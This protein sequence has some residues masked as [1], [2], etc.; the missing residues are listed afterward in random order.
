MSARKVIVYIAASADG[1][2][3]KPN[4][5]LSFLEIVAQEGED[6]GYAEFI[7]TIDTVIVGRKTYDWVMQHVEAFP[8]ADKECYIIT[9]TPRPSM[10]S[11]QFYTG[12]LPLLVNGL[13][14]KTGKHIF[15]DGGA[16]VVNTLLNESLVDELII[17]TIPVLLG[18]GVRLFKEGIPETRLKLLQSKYYPSGLVQQHY[19]IMHQDQV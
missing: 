12:D 11:V 8:H 5:D 3:A 10:G 19:T 15:V 18:N 2:I 14:E 9:R 17:S 4:D 7:S 13:K 16:E 6:Y 1:F